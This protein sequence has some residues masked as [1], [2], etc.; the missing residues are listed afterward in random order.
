[1]ICSIIATKTPNTR[2]AVIL[3]L[4]FPDNITFLKALFFKLYS[5][6]L[7]CIKRVL[8]FESKFTF[9]PKLYLECLL[10]S[11]VAN[12]EGNFLLFSLF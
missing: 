10:M 4:N 9:Y 1:M 12:K 5:I 11:L 7:R 6:S 3:A 2:G 8:Y